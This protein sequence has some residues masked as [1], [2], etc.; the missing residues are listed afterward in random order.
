VLPLHGPEGPTEILR[1]HG[2]A[3]LADGRSFSLLGY[4]DGN[5]LGATLLK[6]SLFGDRHVH[7]PEGVRFCTR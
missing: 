7:G 5:F 6:H 1:G 2:V 3:I 4:E